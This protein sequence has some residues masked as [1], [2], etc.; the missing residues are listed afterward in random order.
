[1]L[2]ANDNIYIMFTVLTSHSDWKHLAW[3]VTKRF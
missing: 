3:S 2:Q 1:L